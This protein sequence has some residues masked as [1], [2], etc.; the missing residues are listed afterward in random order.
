MIV[1][2]S[3]VETVGNTL[4]TLKLIVAVLIVG[5][6]VVAFY[7]FA[8][9]PLLYRVLGMLAGIGVATFIAYHTGKG[10]HIW[11]FFQGAQIEVRKVVWPTR[12]ETVQTTLIVILMVIFI[13]I[14]LW[15]LDMFLGWSIGS[16]MGRGG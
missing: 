14:I 1:M 3:K 15:L 7:L 2:D 8:E 4:D 11:G 5:S 16:L 6:G 12:Q 10:Q 13:A 9:Q